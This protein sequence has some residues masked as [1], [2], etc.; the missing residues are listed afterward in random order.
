L[1]TM[2]SAHDRQDH[3]GVLVTVH[4]RLWLLAKV[5]TCCGVV[6]SVEDW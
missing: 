6:F 5:A 3:L 4:G 2:K 1:I